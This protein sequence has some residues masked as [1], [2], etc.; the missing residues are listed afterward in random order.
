MARMFD[1]TD[2][3]S[4]PASAGEPDYV[5]GYLDGHWQTFGAITARYPSAVGVSITAI[6]GSG[7]DAQVCD[8]ESG[9]YSPAQAAAWARAKLATGRVP[10]IYCSASSWQDVVLACRAVGV[11]QTDVD[12]WI[13]AY[14]G[15]GA[16]LYPGSVAHQ[17]ID[18]G[19]YDE[20]VVADGW[21]PGR[22]TTPPAPTPTPTE[23]DAMTGV[24]PIVTDANGTQHRAFVFLGKLGHAYRGRGGRWVTEDAGAMAGGEAATLTFN[25]DQV[26]DCQIVTGVLVIAAMDSNGVPWEFD[27]PLNSKGWGFSSIL[28]G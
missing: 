21:E 25:Q 13:A 12:W 17:W 2:P 9:D 15:P 14:P 10:C 8:C 20:S 7:V 3:G 23:V 1:T 16:V 4:I 6:P 28:G 19:P 22:S 24:T 5:A 18:R 11:A 27:Q 26:P